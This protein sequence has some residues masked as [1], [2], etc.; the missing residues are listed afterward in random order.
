MY[1]LY[2]LHFFGEILYDDVFGGKR[3]TTFR[4]IWKPEQ[5]EP[6]PGVSGETYTTEEEGWK[7]SGRR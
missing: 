6:V 7:R 3:K 5:R 1:L 2:R 4:Y